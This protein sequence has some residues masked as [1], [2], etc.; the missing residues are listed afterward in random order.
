MA[1]IS[2]IAQRRALARTTD[3]PD[4]RIRRE[5]L[6]HAAA[7]VFRRKGFQAAKLQDIAEEIGKDRASLYYYTSGKDELFQDVV[8]EAVLSNVEMVE[9]LY[10][11]KIPSVGKLRCL[12]TR[13]MESYEK[14]YPYL[15]VYV[16][17]PMAHLDDS[18]EWNRMMIALQKR[19]DDGV[20]GIIRQGMDDGSL[21]VPEDQVRL[22]ANAI[23]GMVSWSHRWFQPAKGVSGGD[24][25]AIFAD[26]ILNGIAAKA[27]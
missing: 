24:I 8:A 15:F 16:Q 19:F 3:D 2:D 14:H 25:G 27:D 13:L 4:Y 22:I 21:T 1:A 12:I 17:E 23:I 6:I 9:H 7:R 20:R 11:D 5:E 18:T 26:A 10:A